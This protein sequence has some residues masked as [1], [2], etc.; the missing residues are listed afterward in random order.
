[1]DIIT[2]VPL[3]IDLIIF[4]NLDRHL[5]ENPK[6]H[7]LNRTSTTPS[8]VESVDDV[9][10][11]TNTFNNFAVFRVTRVLRALRVLRAWKAVKF[12]T[13][14]IS[15]EAFKTMFTIIVLVFIGSGIFIALEYEQGI[16]FHQALYFMFVTISTI[17]Y[18]DYKPETML[19]Q[20]FI[21]VFMTGVF[22]LIPKQVAKLRLHSRKNRLAVV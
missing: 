18:G 10:R 11:R 16:Q 5:F 20:M 13:L 2:I 7:D 3:F 9:V 21:L 14:G 4:L 12:G 22:V 19:G 6:I 8:S 1:M 15:I 17:G